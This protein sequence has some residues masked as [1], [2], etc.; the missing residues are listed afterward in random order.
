MSGLRSG[1]VCSFA[2]VSGGCVVKDNPAWEGSGAEGS[3]DATGGAG[4]TAGVGSSSGS[5]VVPTTGAEQESGG[6][7]DSQ[8]EP[9][10]GAIVPTTGGTDSGELSSTG[11][12]GS[13]SSGGEP[14]AKCMASELVKVDLDMNFL[15]DAGVV[16]DSMGSPCQWGD[17]KEPACGPLN[18]GKTGFFRLVNDPNLGKS[19][20]LLRFDP[21]EV[22]DFIDESR[23]AAEDLVGAR[24]ELVVWEPLAMPAQDSTLEIGML[25][26]EEHRWAEGSRDARPATDNESS[27]L[28]RTREKGDCT[29]W[30]QGDALTGSTSIGLL[31]VTAD[32][33][34]KTPDDGL[35]DQYHA[36]LLSEPLGPALAQAFVQGEAPSLIVSLSSTRGLAEGEIGIKLKESEWD[37]PELYLEVCTQWAP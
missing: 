27:A 21:A 28:C 17:G 26:G 25:V 23:F 36:K 14:V 13:S 12:D 7:T 34:A 11:A 15:V 16:P 9:S 24:L 33:V 32:A 20:A 30:P 18:F 4:G 22:L 6:A 31:L 1:L 29:P 37:D 19:A 10:T 3:A 8:G 35:P 2:A 5:G